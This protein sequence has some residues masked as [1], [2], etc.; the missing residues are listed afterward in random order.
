M[1]EFTKEQKQPFLKNGKLV[2]KA[3]ADL[4][5]DPKFS[6]PTEDQLEHWD[7]KFET[8]IDVKGLKKIT[9][10]NDETN[11][12]IHWLE[13]KGITSKPGWCYGDANFFVF[14][15]KSYWIVVSK[16]D[17]QKFIKDNVIKEFTEKP[18][19]YKLYRRQG[20]LDV[21]T[22]VTSYDLCYISSTIIKKI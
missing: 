8:K 1:S 5:N 20:R 17:I 10:S 7:I 6:T 2:E 16:E 15:L 9:R 11:E 3:F 12:H 21:L 4:F 18:N 13:I 19:L 22:M 14:E